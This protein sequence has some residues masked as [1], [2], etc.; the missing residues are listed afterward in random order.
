MIIPETVQ[1]IFSFIA[2]LIAPAILGALQSRL[3][4]R[5]KSRNVEQGRLDQLSAFLAFDVV[6][7][8]RLIVEQQF[9]TTFG[10]LYEYS[11]IL[12]I[13]DGR[14]PLKALTLMR[15]V[16]HLV[17]FD[18]S[19]RKFKFTQSFATSQQRSRR[20]WGV[21]FA[22]AMSVYAAL[23]PWY[24]AEQPPVPWTVVFALAL[25]TAF[26]LAIAW[27]AL[28]LATDIRAAERFI[29]AIEPFSNIRTAIDVIAQ[30]GPS[31][32]VN[33]SIVR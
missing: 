20:R 17:E 1:H 13:L 31:T 32:T 27:A 9:R 30:S 22:Y 8:D 29:A 33:I 28:D 12:C 21:F 26:F 25:S 18:Q 4:E 7:R 16:R 10:A 2:T 15:T 14:S 3:K 23:G 19:S 5:T 24:F 11:E 6:K